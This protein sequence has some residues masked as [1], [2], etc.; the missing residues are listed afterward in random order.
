MVREWFDSEEGREVMAQA[1]QRFQDKT[2]LVESSHRYHCGGS[3]YVFLLPHILAV[4]DDEEA[5]R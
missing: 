1:M 2:Y 3:E 5:A 4:I